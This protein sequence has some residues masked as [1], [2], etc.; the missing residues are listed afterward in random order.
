LA[1]AMLVLVSIQ[2][3]LESLESFVIRWRPCDSQEPLG[4]D[5]RKPRSV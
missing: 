3:H 5:E 4:V 1:T 2:E